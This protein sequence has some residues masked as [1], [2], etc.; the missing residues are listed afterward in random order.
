MLVVEQGRF[1]DM[2][3]RSRDE[4]QNCGRANSRSFYVSKWLVRIGA[5]GGFKTVS[6]VLVKHNFEGY[7]QR[8]GKILH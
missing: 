7:H 1:L 4:V 8:S 6:F 2:I 3:V 5:K